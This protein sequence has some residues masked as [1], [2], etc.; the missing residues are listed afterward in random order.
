MFFRKGKTDWRVQGEIAVEC[1][2]VEGEVDGSFAAVA[3]L[4]VSVKESPRGGGVAAVKAETVGEV[5]P[6]NVVY[7][8]MVSECV[9]AKV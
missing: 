8:V 3:G 4:G 7:S 2:G 5:R 9:G 1:L 6:E